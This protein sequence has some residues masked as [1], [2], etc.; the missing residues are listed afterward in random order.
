MSYYK[1]SQYV[2]F[3]RIFRDVILSKMGGKRLKAGLQKMMKADATCQSGVKDGRV[4]SHWPDEYHVLY[5][6]ASRNPP[7]RPI[8][9]LAYF[10]RFVKSRADFVFLVKTVCHNTFMKF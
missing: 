5:E 6:K 3:N 2:I 4:T 8:S 10:S 7:N 9:I 1:V